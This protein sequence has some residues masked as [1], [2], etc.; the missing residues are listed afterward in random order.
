LGA[1]PW[2]EPG[3]WA[4]VLVA[5]LAIVVAARHPLATAIGTQSAPITDTVAAAPIEAAAPQTTAAAPQ[6]S[7]RPQVSTHA[8]V[9]PFGALVSAS[10]EL[11]QRPT[12]TGHGR[13][14][15]Q[16][17]TGA[18]HRATPTGSGSS[19][20]SG[21]A[22]STGCAASYTVRA[23]DS[24]WSIANRFVKQTGQASWEQ[25]YAVNR[26]AVGSDPSNVAVGTKLCLSAAASH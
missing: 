18:S 3:V 9:N 7:A 25:L 4:V 13:A 22:S 20:G 24:L 17:G 26:S 5:I 15:D 8:P 12:I 11:Q 19:T 1:L 21:A 16:S 23:G 2:R 10:G 14:V 6:A